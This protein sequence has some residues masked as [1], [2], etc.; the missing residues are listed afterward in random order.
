M[1]FSNT[2]N[3]DLLVYAFHDQGLAP[4]KTINGLLGINTTF[5]LPFVRFSPD[6]GT[7]FSLYG[8]DEA[9]YQGMLYVLEEALV[10][11][12]K[13]PQKWGYLIFNLFFKN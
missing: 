13:A 9:N 2:S 11:Q 12:K 5:G 6:H 4:F 3:S 7:A 1:Q 10:L 8:K